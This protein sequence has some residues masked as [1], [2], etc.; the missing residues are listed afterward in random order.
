M[1][2]ICADERHMLEDQVGEIKVGHVATFSTGEWY[3]AQAHMRICGRDP[4]YQDIR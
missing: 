1:P 3:S 2:A 4:V